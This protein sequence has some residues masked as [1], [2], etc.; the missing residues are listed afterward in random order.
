[1]TRKTATEFIPMMNDRNPRIYETP[2]VRY[3]EATDDGGLELLAHEPY[4]D[5]VEHHVF[6]CDRCGDEEYN[7][8]DMGHHLKHCNE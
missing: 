7:E 6:V 3:H 2:E 5:D 8:S 1:M 4:D